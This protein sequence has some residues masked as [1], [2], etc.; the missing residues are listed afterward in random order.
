MQKVTTEE[1]KQLETTRVTPTY[2]ATV[3]HSSP[4]VMVVCI[5]IL[6]EVKHKTRF[7]LSDKHGSLRIFSLLLQFFELLFFIFDLLFSTPFAADKRHA[8]PRPLHNHI[9]RTSLRPGE[10]A[11]KTIWRAVNLV[12]M[13]KHIQFFR[14]SSNIQT[15]FYWERKGEFYTSYHIRSIS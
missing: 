14:F 8:W 10:E 6:N 4:K 2:N 7:S 1:R 15:L 11:T 13:S 3:V 9:A 12:S 5:V